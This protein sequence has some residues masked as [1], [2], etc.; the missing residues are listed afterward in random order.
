M[1]IKE[2]GIIILAMVTVFSLTACPPGGSTT[3][4]NHDWD[5]TEDAVSA[6][7]TQASEDTATCKNDGCTATNERP[8]GIP[9]LGHD[10]PG[11]AAATCQAIGNTG[12]GTCA[13]CQ[14]SVTGDVIPIEPT[15]HD[16]DWT[17][18]AI[19]ATCM[20]TS[21]DTATCKNAGCTVI[22]ERS[23]S[24]PVNAA[25]H[26]WSEWTTKTPLTCTTAEVLI[27]VCSLCQGD[28]EKPGEPA[29]GHGYVWTTT[30]NP[31]NIKTG[32]ESFMCSHDNSHIANTRTAAS[33]PITTIAEYTTAINAIAS[34]ADNESYSLNIQGAIPVNGSTGMTF[35]LRT[36][37]T[38][39]LSGNGR[40]YLTSAGSLFYIRN[41]QT[42][43]IN[44]SS[45]ILEGIPENNNSLIQVLG[46]LGNIANLE[47]R[48][49]TI[50]GNNAND[51][52]NGFGG[53]VFL[54]HASFSMGGGEIIGN[55]ASQGGGG[56]FVGQG[57]SFSMTG[58]A[59]YSNTTNGSGGGVNIQSGS[60]SSTQFTTISGGNAGGDSNTARANTEGHAVFY[61]SE[62]QGSYYCD[63]TVSGI[64]STSNLTGSNWI[65]K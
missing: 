8:G 10:A 32:I 15:A 46:S 55:S 51:I 64:M 60:F 61:W 24:N 22:N 45:L 48:S 30:T 7:C 14:Q 31:T 50:K 41:N 37:I 40:L 57:S 44:S 21:K 28:E 4:T 29:S 26:D 36:G 49:G 1:K 6:T 38:V 62:S 25:A 54:F 58:G 11:A 52:I 34:G 18:D 17:E 42:L 59:I 23:G 9:A 16:W 12:T 20:E 39:T 3:C 35:G 56:V 33:L 19:A 53:G 2:L 27:R 5:W 47:L 13:R 43:V 65:K 63:Q